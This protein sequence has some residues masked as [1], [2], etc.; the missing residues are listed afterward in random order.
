[1][2]VVQ[3]KPLELKVLETKWESLDVKSLKFGLDKNKFDYK[4]GQYIVLTLDGVKND[5]RG[6]FRDFSIASSP[7]EKG[8]LMISTKISDS[9]FKQKLKSLDKNDKVKVKGP[10]G[11]FVLQ[12]DMTKHAVMLSGGIGI[13]PLRDMIKFAT[14]DNLSVKITLFYSNRVPEEIVYREELDYLQKVNENLTIIHTITRPQESKQKWEGRVGR[15]DKKMI[16]EYVSDLGN[17]IFYICGPPAMVDAM[18]TLLKSMKI[19]EENIGI[20]AT[21][22]EGLTEFGKGKG[23]QCIAAV[24]LK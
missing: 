16:N 11:Q 9:F 8:F 13:T 5:P 21:S 4:P 23:M 18:L 24:T 7:T 17:S 14:D 2:S 3:P 10:F 19:K 12:N 20:A 22:G 6:N 1:M 15:I